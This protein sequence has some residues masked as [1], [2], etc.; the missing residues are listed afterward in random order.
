MTEAN[1]PASNVDRLLRYREVENV[2]GFRRS[3]IYFWMS[4]G[5][6]PKPLKIGRAIAWRERDIQKW[7]DERAE[8]TA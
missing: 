5:L 2:T 7:M 6:F 1:R 4:K 8:A 3:T